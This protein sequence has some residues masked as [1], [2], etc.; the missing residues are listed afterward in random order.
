M[1][2]GTHTVKAVV[3]GTP[4]RPGVVLDGIATSG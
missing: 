3:A 4:G 2:P 1:T